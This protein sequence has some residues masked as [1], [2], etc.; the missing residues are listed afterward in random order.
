M[1][2]SPLEQA[3]TLCSKADLEIQHFNY[4][5]AADLYSRAVA[6]YDEALHLTSS[7]EV[8]ATFYKIFPTSF[9]S[10]VPFIFS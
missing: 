2:A 9:G 1:E 10:L 5:K 4:C 6:K 8:C 3:Y 7:P